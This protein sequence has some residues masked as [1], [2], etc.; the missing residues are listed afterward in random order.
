M[1]DC[2]E[3]LA[4]IFTSL[5]S[6]FLESPS[7]HFSS[8]TSKQTSM[9]ARLPKPERTYRTLFRSSRYVLR[10]SRAAA[11]APDE[12]LQT[13]IDVGAWR[14]QMKDDREKDVTMLT[15]RLQDILDRGG[16][17]IRIMDIQSECNKQ[18]GELTLQRG[19]TTRSH[20]IPSATNRSDC[21]PA[22]RRNGQTP[23]RL[24]KCA[25]PLR[26]ASPSGQQRYQKWGRNQ[27]SWTQCRLSHSSICQQAGRRAFR[28]GA[29][30]DVIRS[31]KKDQHWTPRVRGEGFGGEYIHMSESGV[32]LT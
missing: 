32:L 25:P 23:P 4:G 14:Q 2:A 12:Q 10:C 15:G 22:T 19:A 26:L 21:H 11:A 3:P 6:Y 7:N 28:T 13:Q 31:A 30:T 5:P 8:S 18:S 1:N 17:I 9:L 16:D 29:G 20:C 27:W 24:A